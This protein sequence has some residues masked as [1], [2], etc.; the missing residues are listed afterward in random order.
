[1]LNMICKNNTIQYLVYLLLIFLAIYLSFKAFS[2]QNKNVEGLKN[3]KNNSIKKKLDD[4]LKNFQEESNTLNEFLQLDKYKEEYENIIIALDEYLDLNILS[5]LGN[6]INDAAIE[7]INKLVQLK[8]NLNSVMDS[9]D[10]A[11][12]NVTKKASNFF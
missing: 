4:L 6:N 12:S 1:M 9:L 10:K 2:I 11:H 3:N 5:N 8:E 7:R